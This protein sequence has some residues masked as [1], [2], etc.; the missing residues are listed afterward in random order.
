MPGRQEIFDA[1]IL[2]RKTRL[3]AL[4]LTDDRSAAD[5]IVTECLKRHSRHAVLSDA[6][7][8]DSLLSDVTARARDSLPSQNR[9]IHFDAF[10]RAM[11]GLPFDARACLSLRSNFEL[12]YGRIGVTLGIHPEEAKALHENAI[13]VLDGAHGKRCSASRT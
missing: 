3:Y 2:F 8:L 4:S 5:E 12:D 1:L 7:G 13:D 9:L 6:N 11:Q 10:A